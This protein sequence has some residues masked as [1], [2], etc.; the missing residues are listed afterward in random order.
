MDT[1][2]DILGA[3]LIGGIV[4]L[5]VLNLNV[6]SSETKF[7]SD[8]GLRLQQNA[9]TIADILN[10]DIR[11]VGF[12]YHGMPIKTATQNKFTFYSDIYRT[13]AIDTVTLTTSDS[14]IVTST[15]NPHDKILYMIINGDT[16]KGP[17][18][19]L[20]SLKF[21][22]LNSIEKP[23][24]ILDSVKFIKATIWVESPNKVDTSYAKTYWEV[25]INPRNI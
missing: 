8:S 3:S 12:N 4:L 15:P 14:T 7:K 25:T 21:Y 22:Y 9:K 2:L 20:T 19:G 18:L 6:Y 10:Y 11:K 13:G 17:S 23:T 24:T 16:S 1:I 5:V